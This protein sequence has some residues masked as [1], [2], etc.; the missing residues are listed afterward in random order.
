M[1]E[2]FFAFYDIFTKLNPENGPTIPS[3][4]LSGSLSG[5][6]INLNQV[7]LNIPQ[8]KT[9]VDANGLAAHTEIDLAVSNGVEELL[10]RH[11]CYLV[12]YGNL[13]IYHIK[14]Y[15]VG[16]VDVEVFSTCDKTP[17]A[18]TVFK[19][20]SRNILIVGSD[21]SKTLSHAIEKSIQ[22]AYM[23]FSNFLRLDKKFFKHPNL[24][25][26]D[27][28]TLYKTRLNHLNSKVRG[29]NAPYKPDNLDTLT[30]LG[31]LKEDCSYIKLYNSDDISV[32]RCFIQG[33]K[34]T[35]FD[36]NDSVTPDPFC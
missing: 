26:L 21:L 1:Y 28:P 15:N 3:Y 5:N 2:R 22:E 20:E 18:I 24:V 14:S 9:P 23:L 16:D 11:I 36:I 17:F 19:D 35:K 4:S 7:L 10:E 31:F 34:N 25:T 32:V 6:T 8:N 12:W 13:N 27:D 29:H 33:A 30:H